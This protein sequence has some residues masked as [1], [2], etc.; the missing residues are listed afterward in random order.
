MPLLLNNKDNQIIVCVKN[1]IDKNNRRHMLKHVGDYS[2]RI[3][4]L[5]LNAFWFEVISSNCYSK[6]PINECNRSKE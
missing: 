1:Y 3:Y 6:A 4:A 2:I 5:F